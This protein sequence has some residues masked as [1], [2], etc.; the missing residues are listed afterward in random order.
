MS[1][2]SQKKRKQN[3]AMILRILAKTMPVG[4]KDQEFRAILELEG[5]T[6]NKVDE[7]LNTLQMAGRIEFYEET[8]VWRLP[9]PDITTKGQDQT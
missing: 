4:A 9:L 7:M 6:N 1:H 5:L 3:F 8:R 2:H